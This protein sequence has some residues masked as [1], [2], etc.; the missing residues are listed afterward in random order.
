MAKIDHEVDKLLIGAADAL[1]RKRLTPEKQNFWLI[2]R[3]WMN[4]VTRT[5]IFVNE[6][7]WKSVPGFQEFSKLLLTALYME[8]L[9]VY[10]DSLKKAVVEMMANPMLLSPVLQIVYKKTSAY[11]YFAV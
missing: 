2:V 10:S 8:E 3:E 9:Q 11:N 4:C 7:Q 6:I 1:W 5:L